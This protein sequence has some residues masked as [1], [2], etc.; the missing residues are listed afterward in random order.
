M[1]LQIDNKSYQAGYGEGRS[2]ESSKS[3]EELVRAGLDD[4]SYLS[5]FIEGEAKRITGSEPEK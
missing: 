2:G 4:L 1:R 5:G 3:H